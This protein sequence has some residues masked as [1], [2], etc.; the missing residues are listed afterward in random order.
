MAMKN[1][2]AKSTKR[3]TDSARSR[4]AKVA[5]YDR[6]TKSIGRDAGKKAAYKAGFEAGK[7]GSASFEA[8]WTYEKTLTLNMSAKECD[9]FHSGHWAGSHGEE[10]EF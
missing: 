7:A 9:A 8:L 5:E 10:S 3:N 4:A 1:W 6:Y 2:T